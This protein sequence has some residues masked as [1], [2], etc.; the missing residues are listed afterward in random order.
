MLGEEPTQIIS[1]C[2]R[3]LAGE[4]RPAFGPG[5]SERAVETPWVASH[6]K[7]GEKVLDIGFTMSSLDYLGL[8]LEL[9]RNHKVTIEAVDIVKPERVARRYPEEWRAEVMEVPITIGDLRRQD[10]PAGRYDIAT[11]ISTIEHI[12]FDEATYDDPKSAFA[13]STT[14][15]GVKLHRDPNVNRDV[16]ARLHDALKPGGLVL[17]SVPMG[18][19]GPALLEDS[20]GFF[21]A[22]WEY[23]AAS[24]REVVDAKG[25]EVVEQLFYRLDSDDVWRQVAGPAELV[26]QSSAMTPHAAGCALAAL[27]RR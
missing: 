23:E 18:T 14:K 16:L 27:R 6:F 26:H 15:E 10:L 1:A 24:W 21:C 5:F 3:V 7:G 25:F 13:R 20:L 8:L 4:P 12:G 19:G 11:I 9:R 2:K 17:I 22:Q